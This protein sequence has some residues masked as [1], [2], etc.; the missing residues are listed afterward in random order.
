MDILRACAAA[1]GGTGQTVTNEAVGKIV[2]LSASTVSLAN[3]FFVDVG[4]VKRIE[5]RHAPSQEVLDYARVHQWDADYAGH[6]LAP[7]VREAWFG[8][9]LLPPLSFSPMAEHEAVREL[10]KA[11]NAEPQYRAQ[12][13][14]LLDYMAAVGLIVLADGH[15]RLG[16]DAAREAPPPKLA[17]SKPPVTTGEPMAPAAGLSGPMPLLLQGLLERL[18]RGGK[19]DRGQATQWLDYAKATF[20]MVYEFDDPPIAPKPS[21]EDTGGG[22]HPA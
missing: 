8:Q 4:F 11:G 18:P 12:V 19:W 21:P 22:D 6:E 3:G 9:A 20:E 15:V 13:R 17:E 1:S 14:M 5:G 7:L 10:A 16:L 2:G